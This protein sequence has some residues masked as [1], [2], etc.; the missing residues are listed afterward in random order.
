MRALLLAPLLSLLLLTGPAGAANDEAARLEKARTMMEL[1]GAAS[2]GEQTLAIVTQ[3]LEQAMIAQN[4]GQQEQIKTLIRN[5]FL[6]NAKAG[7]PDLLS[8]IAGLYAAHFTEAELDQIIAF[9]KT[10]IG[11]KTIA[12]IPAILQ[13]STVL[14]RAW[15]ENV[16]GQALQSF[17]AA[18]RE[19]GLAVPKQL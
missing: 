7:L 4:P 14:G 9:Y 11:H 6:P 8:G 10:P 17:A 18:A 3:Q 13:Q 5:H 15:S 16:V 2:L 1:T 12:E 19:R